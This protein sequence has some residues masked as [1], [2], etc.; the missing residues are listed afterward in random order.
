MVRGAIGGGVVSG[1]GPGKYIIHKSVTANSIKASRR[2][3]ASQNLHTASHPVSDPVAGG[4]ITVLFGEMKRV[5]TARRRGDYGSFVRRV[6]CC[7]LLFGSSQ[8]RFQMMVCRS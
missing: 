2:T 7:E 8:N 6:L 4:C 5:F 1:G 3:E